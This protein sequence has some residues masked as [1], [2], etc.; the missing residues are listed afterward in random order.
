MK[1]RTIDLNC[2]LGERTDRTGIAEELQL[3][4][5]VSSVNVACGG[6]AGDA[7]SMTRVVEAALTRGVAVGAHPSYPDRAGFGRA[8][9]DMPPAA[10]EDVVAAQ[11][12]ALVEVSLRVG[13]TVTHVKPHGALYHAAARRAETAEAVARGVGRVAG[14]VILVGPSGSPALGVWRGLGFRIAGEAF[15]DRRYERDGT[16]RSRKQA[17]AVFTCPADVAAQAVRVA[18]GLGAVAEDGTI[19]AIVA[20]TLCIHGDSPS[21]V[22]SARA[23]HQ[24]LA[25][26]GIRIRPLVG[27]SAATR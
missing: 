5:F 13:A 3:L 27:G 9:Q 10:L 21:A 26:A 2:D 8:E 22:E 11:V 25:D 23:V 20:D 18:R 16:L 19:V 17:G 7:D 14:P 12:A 15:A 1:A 24:A 4:E 6:H